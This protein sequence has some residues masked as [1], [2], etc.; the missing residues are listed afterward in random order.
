MFPIDLFNNLRRLLLKIPPL[1]SLKLDNSLLNLPLHLLR[2]L[3]L[4]PEISAPHPALY[5][6]HGQ[7]PIR[8]P[9]PSPHD[10]IT[11]LNHPCL[12][13]KYLTCLYLCSIQYTP[14]LTHL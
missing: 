3:P 12:P 14:Y 5:P 10:L 1:N 7:P 8:H 6:R 4:H 13:I 9:L 11:P 2:S